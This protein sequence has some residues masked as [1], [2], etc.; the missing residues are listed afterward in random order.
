MKRKEF[1]QCIKEDK[2]FESGIIDSSMAKELLILAE[3]REKFWDSVNE[4]AKLFPSLFIEGFYEI[5]KELGTAIIALDGWK[6][7]NHECLFAYLKQKKSDLDL[8]FEYLLELKDIRNSIDYRG[9][10]VSYD[11]WKKNELRIKMIVKALKNYLKD[12]C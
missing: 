4:K 11:L 6:A 10:M 12:K 9:T 5:I 2:L 3:H 8:D 7:L 1:E